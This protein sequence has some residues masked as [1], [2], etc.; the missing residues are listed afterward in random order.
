MPSLKT[1][2][3]VRQ[4]QLEISPFDTAHIDVL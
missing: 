1:W 2:L 4:G 3:G